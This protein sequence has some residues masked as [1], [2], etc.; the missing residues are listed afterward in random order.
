MAWRNK[1]GCGCSGGVRALQKCGAVLCK[2]MRTNAYGMWCAA[3]NTSAGM[4][5]T[6]VR[7]P[8]V[9][10]AARN[11]RLRRRVAQTK[12]FHH[13]VNWQNNPVKPATGEERRQQGVVHR[14]E[15]INVL[16]QKNLMGY[17][18]IQ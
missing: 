9:R 2:K 18:I 17:R 13:P 3:V 14:S 12:V 5:T 16:A 6:T 4:R 1:P 15:L 11:A 8:G 7:E 10:H